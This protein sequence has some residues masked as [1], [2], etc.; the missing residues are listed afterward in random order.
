M[1]QILL[2]LLGL[3]VAIWYLRDFSRRKPTA[4]SLLAR[5]IGGPLIMALGL[6][7]VVGRHFEIGI[8]MLVFGGGLAGW[9]GDFVPA[10]LRGFKPAWSPGSR[11]RSPMLEVQLDGSGRPVGGRVLSGRLAGRSLDSLYPA[12]FEALLTEIAPDRRGRLFLEA[13]LDGRAP[14]WREHFQEHAAAGAGKGAR[15]GAM[16]KEE[17]YKILGIEPGATPDEVRRAHRSLM[18]KLH[19][20]H[21]GSTYLAARVNEAKDV[22]LDGHR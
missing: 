6:V 12:D 22:I 18:K 10:P 13:Y 11:V 14:G 21:G 5:R 17:A 9:L 7:M 20:D 8:P 4:A 15:S 16:A 2:G 19:P 3:A 1:I